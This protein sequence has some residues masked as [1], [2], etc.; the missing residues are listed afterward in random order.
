MLG[1]SF[2]TTGSYADST[3]AVD[4]PVEFIVNTDHLTF[5]QTL[6]I[7]EKDGSRIWENAD[8]PLAACDIRFA[9][10]AGIRFKT[11]G[12]PANVNVLWTF[13]KDDVQILSFSSN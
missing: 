3:V 5:M 9:K 2:L 4:R 1:A 6:R 12:T 11:N 10:I 13:S 7:N 8:I